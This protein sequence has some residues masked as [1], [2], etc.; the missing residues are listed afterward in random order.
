MATLDLVEANRTSFMPTD[1]S[2]AHFSKY[3][4]TVRRYAECLAGSASP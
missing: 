2:T 4:F 1:P 3:R